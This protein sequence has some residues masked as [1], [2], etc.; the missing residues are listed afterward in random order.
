MAWHAGLQGYPGPQTCISFTS[1]SRRYYIGVPHRAR[2][3][4]TRLGSDANA[5]HSGR[6]LSDKETPV[7]KNKTDLIDWLGVTRLP[8]LTK[9]RWLG[10][11]ISVAV[12]TLVAVVVIATLIM[13]IKAVTGIADFATPEAQS[14]AIRNTGLALAALVGLPFLVWRSAI[15]QK[16]TNTAVDSLFNDKINAAAEDLHAQRQITK[17]VMTPQQGLILRDI[18]QDNVTRRNAA[19]DRLEGLAQERPDSAPRISRLLSVYVRELSEKIGP[20]AVPEDITPE[21]LRAATLF[22]KRSDMEN[23]V[24][25]LGRLRQ[26]D[27]VQ[28]DRISIDL[29]GA[30]LQGFYLNDLDFGTAGMAGTQLQGALLIRAQ[31]QGADLRKAQMDHAT[32]F[33]A[34][35]LRGACVWSL[36]C[37]KVPY[38]LDHLEDIFGD[39]SVIL[40]DGVTR[41]AHWLDYEAELGDFEIPWRAWQAEIG[42]DPDNPDT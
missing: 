5:R 30:N 25:T 3:P 32:F 39:A 38:I 35:T 42:F 22:D 27:R 18:W 34:T 40:P 21:D 37:T 7:R 41:P 33:S 29:R 11:V 8:D 13:F 28:K 15:A 10:G 17:E 20:V 9:A 4:Q 16:Q 19:I 31:L 24:Q 2:L 36:D 1:V 26:I 6:H 14:E 23:A 12:T